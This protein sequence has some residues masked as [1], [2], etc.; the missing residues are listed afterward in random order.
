VDNGGVI[1][2][3]LTA[4]PQNGPPSPPTGLGGAAV[5]DGQI[6]LSWNASLGATSYNVLRSTTSGSGYSTLATGVTGTSY[7]DNTAADGVKRYYYEVSAVN[8][9]GT[10]SASTEAGILAALQL[11][12]SFEDT[13][14]STTDSISSASLAL[15]NG[16]NT[17]ADLHGAVGSG[18]DGIGKALDFSSN[19]YNSPTTGPLLSAFPSR[20]VRGGHC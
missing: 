7:T 15:V 17:P 8:S 1:D 9:N 2:L 20:S 5:A 18:V 10:S 19:P 6:A 16:A 12:F 11:R 14:T 13:G 3:V 4:G